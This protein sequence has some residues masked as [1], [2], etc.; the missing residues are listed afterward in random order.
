MRAMADKGTHSHLGPISFAA[1]LVLAPALST[2]GVFEA[3][4]A[5]SLPASTFVPL[6]AEHDKAA[7]HGMKTLVILLDGL[8]SDVAHALPNLNAIAARGAETEIEIVPPTISSPQYVA[9]LTGVAPADSGVRSNSGLYRIALDN[10]AL[11]VQQ[12][13]AGITLEIGDDVDWWKTMFGPSFNEALL[14]KPAELLTTAKT[15]L[16]SI[17]FGLVHLCA[18]DNAG[19]EHGASGPEY[20]AAAHEV[21]EATLVLAQTWGWPNVNLVVISDHGHRP[22]GGH[23]SDDPDVRFTRMIVSGGM[24]KRAATA[25]GARSI[26][27]APTLAALLGV[28]APAQAQGRSLNELLDVDDGQKNAL[29]QSDSA[30][31]A[32]IEPSLQHGRALAAKRERREQILR[33]AVLTI[34]LAI[35]AS[36]NWKRRIAVAGPFALGFLHLALTVATYGASFGALSFAAARLSTLLVRDVALFSFGWTIVLGVATYR[37]WT[38]AKREQLLAAA[39]CASLGAGV[40]ACASFVC[41]GVSS[42]RFTFSPAWVAAAPLVSFA[43][44]AAFAAGALALVVGREGVR[45]WREKTRLSSTSQVTPHP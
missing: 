28:S 14:V 15:K 34:A 6:P 33:G 9:F 13:H 12:E 22:K 19:H 5:L 36:L 27:V 18:V 8:R 35:V 10:V 41:A 38:R 7:T 43:S 45:A 21:D 42:S 39:T 16:R 2:Y 29:A 4:A 31:L 17:E 11:R 37:H 3:R 40:L 25:M 1:M 44:Y 32:R 23:G 26:D 30:R 24:A 20:A